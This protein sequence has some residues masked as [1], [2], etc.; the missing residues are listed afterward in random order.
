MKPD[1]DR[2]MAEYKNSKTTLI[3]DVDCTEGGATLCQE[4]GVGGY[5]TIK[6]GDPN[7]L[8]DY[9]GGRDFEAL[10]Q[11]AQENLGPTCGPGNIDLCDS[12]QKKLIKMYEAMS[13]AQLDADIQEKTDRI[14]TLENDFKVWVEGLSGQYDKQSAERDKEVAEVKKSGLGLMKVVLAHLKAKG[15]L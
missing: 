15:E 3:A 6:Y 5:P 10:K 1:W 13:E 8:E 12:E 4:K 9:S 7:S 2:L 14:A 11:F